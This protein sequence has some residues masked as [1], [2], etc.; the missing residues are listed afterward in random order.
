[1]NKAYRQHTLRWSLALS[2][3]LL[4]GCAAQSPKPFETMPA[5]Q[6]AVE[7]GVN[8]EDRNA[9]GRLPDAVSAA[10]LPPININVPGASEEAIE[11]RFDVKVR[12]VRA[13][14]FFLSLVEDTPHNIIVHPEVSGYISLN[15]KNVTLQET[16]EAVR[17]V[18]GYDYEQN[19]TGYQIFPNKI[20]TRIFHVDYLDIQRQGRSSTRVSSGQVSMAGSTGDGGDTG[21]SGGQG[22]S[23][24]V[25]SSIDTNSE[26]DFWAE[27][28]QA[29]TALV[30]SG[31]GRRVTVNPQSGIITV[32]AMP[33]ELRDVAR[34]LEATQTVIQRQVILE[35]RILEVELSEGFQSGINWS[36]LQTDGAD[37]LVAGQVG[38]GSIF[39]GSGVTS[40]TGSAGSLNPAAP[41]PIDGTATSAFGGM[42]TLALNNAGDFTAFI[43]LLKTQGNV[44]VLSSPRV[45]TV[46]NQ[47][48]VIKVGADEFFVTEVDTNTTTGTATTTNVTVE[49]TPFFSG[50]ALDV[51][52]QIGRAGDITLH[53]HPAVSEVSE[54]VKNINTSFATLTMP[55]AA[56]TIRESDS[57][58][59]AQ[60]GQV[61][62]IG[63]LMQTTKTEEQSSVPV[64]GDIPL[65]GA[66]FRHTR[67][68]KRKSE[69]VILLKPT[70]V[71]GSKTW[72]KSLQ[73]SAERFKALGGNLP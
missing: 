39:S 66:L 35:A 68:V 73:G 47:K 48:A 26:S 67:E 3:G 57:V 50:V 60:N 24:G 30:G 16:L 32:R 12:R 6:E 69:L 52:P 72:S 41:I 56:S 27:L 17:N 28:S 64:L 21:D 55:L 38:G 22:G 37:S 45:S 34:Y 43:E 40:I 5:I 7:E 46:N 15:L 62:V 31:E 33:N 9:A 1:M 14:D 61:V 20:R 44:Q 11:T 49:L 42:F 23:S 13:R 53:I 59:R 4:A 63:G 25:G 29:V 65:L 18:Y 70:I 58:I 51:I 54:Q 8:P 10:L 71:E 19:G 36:S 2:L